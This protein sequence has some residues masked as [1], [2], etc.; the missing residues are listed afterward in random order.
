VR[1]PMRTLPGWVSRAVAAA[2]LAA[3]S[4][5]AGSPE[6]RFYLLTP[7]ETVERSAETSPG[8]PP[9]VGLRPIGLP[10]HLD[11]EEIV[12]RVGE[13]RLHLAELDRWAAPLRDN[14]ARVL[15]E[16]LT[17]LLPVERVLLFPWKKDGSV[18]VEVSVE[19][20]RLEGALGGACSLGADWALFR[21]GAGEPILTGR[22]KHRE[23]AGESYAALVAAH[24]RLIARLARD[25]AA[26]LRALPRPG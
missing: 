26:A 1:Y 22:S 4:A 25:I 18:E 9:A 8:K 5:C 7:L 6:T 3:L 2:A 11:R 13:N 14:L 19:V 16:D 15:A 10:A 17:A 24:S 12:T 23:P 21:K 20:T